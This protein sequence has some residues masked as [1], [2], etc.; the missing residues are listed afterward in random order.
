[1]ASEKF[2]PGGMTTDVE[3]KLEFSCMRMR[4]YNSIYNTK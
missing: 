2:I 3:I 1:M 4:F